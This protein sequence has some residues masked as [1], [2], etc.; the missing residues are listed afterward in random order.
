[1]LIDFARAYG[2]N[3]PELKTSL[4]LLQT[5]DYFNDGERNIHSHLIEEE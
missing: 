4:T 3:F 2:K 1:M 5:Y